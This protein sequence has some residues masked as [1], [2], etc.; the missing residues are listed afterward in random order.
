MVE[1]KDD[2]IITEPYS[3]PKGTKPFSDI[4]A[5]LQSM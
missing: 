2:V 1:P 4:P 3:E 5:G